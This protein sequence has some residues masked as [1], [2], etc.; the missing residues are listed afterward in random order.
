MKAMN[1]L[2]ER[3]RVGTRADVEITRR[4][5]GAADKPVRYVIVTLLPRA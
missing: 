2:A 3:G 5:A 1:A 4:F